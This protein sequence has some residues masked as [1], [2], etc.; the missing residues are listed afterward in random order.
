MAKA[1]ATR[2]TA[3]KTM[4]ACM[5][6][7]GYWVRVWGGPDL[8]LVLCSFQGFLTVHN[9]RMVGLLLYSPHGVLDA[10]NGDSRS[11]HCYMSH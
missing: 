1:V 11:V 3:V 6:A 8:V 5:I 2:V 10:R 4:E 9:E 7:G